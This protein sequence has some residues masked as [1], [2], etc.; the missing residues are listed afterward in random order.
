MAELAQLTAPMMR[1]SACFHAD[2]ARWQRLEERQQLRAL[3]GFVEDN[4]AALRNAVN[5]KNILGQIQADGLYCPWVAPFLAVD[6]N[7]TLAHSMP[8]EQE[9][10]TSSG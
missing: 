1:R 8:V 9:P 3:D 4:S 2:R 10:P 7:C 6:N 5:L